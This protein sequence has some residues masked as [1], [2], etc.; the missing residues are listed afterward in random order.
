DLI[1]DILDLSKVESGKMVLENIPCQPHTV[2][3]DAMAIFRVRANEKNLTLDFRVDG[4]I[5]Q[6]ISADP[7]RL[8]QIL[9]NL[10]GNA[11]KFT[12]QGGVSIVC[13]LDEHDGNRLAFDVVD[14]GIGITTEQAETIF[15]PFSQADSSTTRKF[16]GTG[17][18]L[19]ISR[20]LAEMMGGTITAAGQPGRG[21]CFT[22]TIDPGPLDG[23]PLLSDD[24]IATELPMVEDSTQE[25]YQL[26]PGNV[27][28]VDDGESNRRLIQL[29]LERAGATVTA[30][31]NGAEAVKAAGEQHFDI[32]LMDVMMPVM[33]GYEATAT[34]REQQIQVPIIALTAHAMKEERQRALDS[35]FDDFIAKPVNIDLLLEVVAE[36]LGGTL[37]KRPRTS[38]EAT[39]PTLESTTVALTTD[40]DGQP[41]LCSLPMDDAEFL[42][43]ARQFRDRLEEQLGAMALL[44][45]A[46]D[47]TQLAKQAHW[48]KGAGGTAGFAALTEPA[49]QLEQAAKAHDAAHC[50]TWIDHLRQMASAIWL[51][52]P[53]S[54]AVSDADATVPQQKLQPS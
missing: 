12:E 30:A 19:P 41:L 20:K 7:L 14:T 4:K 10:I 40:N 37:Q 9:T 39:S 48:L 2:V 11:I 8:R 17:L 43:I 44:W 36:H 42:E 29:V 27:L 3:N 51:P 16:G 23:V 33:D 50:E 1:N 34:L 5:P 52:E 49:R 21:S 35:G 38:S 22:V 47:Y 46:G 15:D 25:D 26:P 32:V 18:G 24:E 28:V 53:T 6:Q 45:A 31:V 13:R 54:P